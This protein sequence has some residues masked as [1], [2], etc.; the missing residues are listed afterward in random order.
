M[1]N[2]SIILVFNVHVHFIVI[3]DHYGLARVHRWF[4]RCR[5]S[6]AGLRLLG[7]WRTAESVK[8]YGYLP[9][10]LDEQRCD[11]LWSQRQV[12]NPEENLV[13]ILRYDV[14]ERFFVADGE[15]LLCNFLFTLLVL[16]RRTSASPQAVLAVVRFNPRWGPRT[17]LRTPRPV[18]LVVC[19]A[20]AG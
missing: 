5:R 14:D 4:A 9:A 12:V 7:L 3:V 20:L 18:V 10:E 11:V 17:A 6:K 15:L 16:L 13:R 1:K 2:F 19:S 8:G